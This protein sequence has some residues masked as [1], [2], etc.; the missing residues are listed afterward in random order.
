MTLYEKLTLLNTH[1]KEGYHAERICSQMSYLDMLSEFDTGADK[2][3][4]EQATDFLLAECGRDGVITVSAMTKAE[5]MLAPLAPVAKSYTELFVSHAHIDMNWMWG[6]NETVSLTLDT[7]RTILGLMREYPDFTFAQSQA[8]TYEIVEKYCP[9][10]LDEIKQRV[11]EGRWEVTAAEWVEPDKNMPDGESLTRHIIKTREYLSSLLDIA[12]ESLDLDFVPD[13]FGHNINVPEILV[14]AGVKY[15][16]HCRGENLPN[17]YNYVSPS[18]KRTLNYCENDWY[19]GTIATNKF[20]MLPDFCKR[21]GVKT[22]LVCYGVGDHGG[23]PTRRDIEKITEYSKWPLTP[24]IRFGTFRDFFR[25]VEPQR[26][27]FP[28]VGCELN[29]IFTGCYTTQSRIKM[30]N[31]IS[32]ARINDAET[33]GAITGMLGGKVAGAEKLDRAWKNILFNHFHDILP[34]SGT[35]ETREYAMGKFQDTLAHVSSYI[36]SSMHSIASRIST[37]SVPFEETGGTVS[38]GGGVGY[39]DSESSAFRLGSAER[40]RGKVRAFHVFNTLSFERSEVCDLTMWDYNYDISELSV[41]D[42]DGNSLE[43]HITPG[44]T[45]YWGHSFNTL[46]VK[47]TIPAFGYNTVIVKPKNTKEFLS[48]GRFDSPRNDNYINDDDIVLENER[49]RAVFNHSTL[50]LTSLTDKKTGE[51]LI[52]CS[53]MFFRLTDENPVYGMTSWRVGP[54]MKVQNL[55][56][57]CG[58][59]LLETW[60]N[61]VSRGLK[62]ELRF[63]RSVLKAVVSLKNGDPYLCVKTN[64]DWHEEPEHGIRIPQLSFA[65]PVSYET[66]GK[67]VCDVPYG[68][69]ERQAVS[70]DV[71]CLSYI[72]IGGKTEH[73]VSIITDSKY[74]YRCTGQTGSVTLLRSSYD[75]D[76]YPENG[77]HNFTIAVAASAKHALPYIS[78]RFC[79]PALYIP[80]VRHEGGELPL[81]GSALNVSGDVVVSSLKHAENGEGY[82][83]RVYNLR[84]SG[85]ACRITMRSDIKR[86]VLTDS[87][88][89]PLCD[90]SVEG[91]T[92]PLAVDPYATSTAVIEI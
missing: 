77:I 24:S 20:E 66:D 84:E 71:P 29:C 14:S 76:P 26:D 70:H 46:Q 91:S 30:A 8:S 57:T 56:E 92:V 75:P 58:A 5:E 80:A 52:S 53:S 41:T 50:E 79:H 39:F 37:E 28:D 21:N 69:I 23:G 85:Q 42:A 10:M 54:A 65:V 67:S 16:Y 61:A 86:A 78:R 11:H 83:V 31:R 81:C 27:S 4:L 1:R 49:I 73:I 17:L 87:T 13:T 45:G 88:E 48:A 3:L 40:G 82:A 22:F 9:E 34:G 2:S 60:S 12:P 89:T 51:G 64:V 36:S 74:G 44:K 90:L 7:F 62:Y 32:E 47:V 59:R 18:G 63:G 43:Y 6:Y 15:M 25:A 19:N 35:I 38:E 33:L 68:T 72:G 55:N